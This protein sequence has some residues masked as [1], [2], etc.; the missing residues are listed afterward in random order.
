MKNVPLIIIVLV[1]SLVAYFGLS[2]KQVIG[3][4]S[5]PAEI[6]ASP[7]TVRGVIGCIPKIGT[8]PQ[9]MECALGL[10]STE[11]I[12]YGLKYL[13]DHDE[14]FELVSPEIN[15][16]IT[17]TLVDEEMFGPDGNKYDTAGTIEIG[18]VVEI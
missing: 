9:T 11:G 7:I 8:G 10:Q 2:Q 12:Y 15:V 13:S 5:E 1:L 4:P 3:V 6:I 14:N 18:S 17:G 16:E